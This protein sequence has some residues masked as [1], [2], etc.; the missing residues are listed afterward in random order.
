M[1]F[2]AEEDSSFDG[3]SPFRVGEG[4][5]FTALAY[6][7]A[8]AMVAAASPV[9]LYGFNASGSGD[10]TQTFTNTVHSATATASFDVTKI[11]IFTTSDSL[12]FVA[13]GADTWSR[14]RDNL[15]GITNFDSNSPSG[16]GTLAYTNGGFSADFTG[17]A[18]WTRVTAIGLAIGVP[19]DSSSATYTGNV[20]YKYDLPYAFFFEP[21]V[22]VSYTETYTANFGTKTGDMT[23]VHG[24]ARIGTEMKWMGYTIQPT[25]SGAVFKIVDYSPAVAASVSDQLGGRGSAKINV[26]WTP[27]FS[28][29][30]E[31]HGSGIAGTKTL[32]NLST[33]TYGASGGLRYSWY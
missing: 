15:F 24:G 21:T 6:A 26:I 11:G 2:T 17:T 33:N 4:S 16:S 8:P 19:A 12:T 31:A 32:G 25:L 29:W 27:N 14:Q 9:W 3:R 22:G 13:T 10:R 1:R 7:K 30:I 5:P 18:S 20:Q 28:S 23:E